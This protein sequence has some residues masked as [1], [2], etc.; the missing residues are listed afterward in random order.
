MK[1]E[2]QTFK[3][4]PMNDLEKMSLM[5]KNNMDIRMSGNIVGAQKVKAGG[6]ITMGIDSQTFHEISMEMAANDHKHYVVL[7]VINK[8]Q[9]DKL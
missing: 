2:K 9:F 1:K 5:V 6:H 3:N 8:E 4:K 7:Y